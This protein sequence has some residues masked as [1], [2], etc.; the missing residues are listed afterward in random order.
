MESLSFPYWYSIGTLMPLL[1]SRLLCAQHC[2]PVTKDFVLILKCLRSREQARW[3]M[4]SQE[5]QRKGLPKVTEAAITRGVG[6]CLLRHRL[7]FKSPET[8]VF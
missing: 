2:G 7:I 6:M 3:E 4:K 8:T 1:R 5:Q